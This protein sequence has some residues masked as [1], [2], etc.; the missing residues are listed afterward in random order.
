MVPYVERTKLGIDFVYTDLLGA[1]QNSALIALKLGL[2]PLKSKNSSVQVFISFGYQLM[3]P[4]ERTVGPIVFLY[5][6]DSEM[7]HA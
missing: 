1:R 4:S 6:I 2:M 3:M 7:S 5:E